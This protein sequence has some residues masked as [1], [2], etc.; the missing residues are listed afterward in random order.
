MMGAWALLLA[1]IAVE[2]AATSS[3]PRTQGFREPLWT[4]AAVGGYAVSIW[5]LALVVQRLPV[6][7]TYA[8]WAGLGTAGI[9]LVGV[10]LLGERLGPAQVAGL[11]LII[12]GV[13]ILNLTGPR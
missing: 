7:I 10:F 4:A 6:S 3:L 12:G 1:A 9:V 2:V 13:V 8:V 5:L 11:A